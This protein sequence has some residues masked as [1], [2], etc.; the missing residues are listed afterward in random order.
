MGFWWVRERERERFP[1]MV[2]DEG[3]QVLMPRTLHRL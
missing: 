3:L 1:A 2:Q